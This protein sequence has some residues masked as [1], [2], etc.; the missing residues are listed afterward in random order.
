M[1]A[2]CPS[3]VH[4]MTRR[5]ALARVPTLALTG[6]CTPM[7]A[8][9]SAAPHAR[10]R[11]RLVKTSPRIEVGDAIVVQLE[12]WVSTWFQAP[13][14][15][16][17]T[18]AAEGALVEAVGGSPDSRF[19]E[20]DGQRWTGL[21]RRYRLLPVQPG[22]IKVE[23]AEPIAVQPGGGT[24]RIHALRPSSALRLAVQ[25][26]KGAE[27]LQPFVAARRF[28][29]SQRWLPAPAEGLG[30]LRAG[31]VVRREIVLVTDST[32]PWIPLP[33]FGSP[34][35]V[36]VHVQAPATDEKRTHAAASPVLTRSQLATYTLDTH[37]SVELPA[38]EMAWWDLHERRVRTSR[39][40]TLLL[41]IQPA[42]LRPDPFA[43]PPP[44]IE[45][46][47]AAASAP[48]VA[49][50]SRWLPWVALVS[51]GVA[52]TYLWRQHRQSTRQRSE[53]KP[54]STLN[55]KR[56]AGLWIA[57]QRNDAQAALQRLEALVADLPPP[58]Q[59]TWLQDG[60]YGRARAEL[61]KSLYGRTQAPSD[62]SGT[63]LWQA[64]A[65]M[66]R[67]AG[68]HRATG[69]SLPSLLP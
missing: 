33:D 50:T 36:T 12:V 45:A 22:D 5:K 56:W 30:T 35:G 41:T 16:P 61:E 14:E 38:I 31:D 43:P 27:S 11:W 67:T 63:S 54:A 15:F 53:S 17:S 21:I 64:V 42:S 55:W 57:C 18:L 47:V 48:Q 28:Q 39:L 69:A 2:G 59:S 25:L 68:A 58:E 20:V 3:S 34:P 65:R 6:L 19:E 4:G 23:L 51:S 24:G 26:P 46:P 62:W 66:R 40:D 32:S 13:I 7:I 10:I 49:A 1:T 44:A 60:A 52:A 29:L 37:G 8:A 9:A